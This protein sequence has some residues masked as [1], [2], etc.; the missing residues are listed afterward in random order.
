MTLDVTEAFRIALGIRD[1]DQLAAVIVG[2]AVVETHERLGVAG[3]VAAD[4]RA[5]MQAR[6]DEDADLPIPAMRQHQRPS[7]HRAPAI[8]AG[9]RHL[10]AVA[11]IEPGPLEDA[12]ELEL[13]DLLRG[14]AR[15]VNTEGS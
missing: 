9:L 10:G 1:T 8:V 13:H 11:H 4:Q 5:A 14:H 12:L 15:S 6:I 3:V 7:E 2:P